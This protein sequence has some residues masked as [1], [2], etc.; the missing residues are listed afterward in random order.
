MRPEVMA[1]FQNSPD[2]WTEIRVAE[3]ITREK[4]RG[5]ARTPFQAAQD[6]LSAFSKLMPRKEQRNFLAACGRSSDTTLPNLDSDV[7]QNP[8]GLPL[9]LPIS[10]NRCSR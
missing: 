1:C 3:K 4:E 2:Q 8:S 9:H 5:L 7:S 6:D 10:I